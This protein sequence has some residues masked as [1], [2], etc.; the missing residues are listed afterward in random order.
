M[1]QGRDHARRACRVG[2]AGWPRHLFDMV[3]FA[4]CE[5]EDLG[6]Y[7]GEERKRLGEPSW[8]PLD[9]GSVEALVGEPLDQ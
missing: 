4:S 9:R 7:R 5:V 6:R 1:G 2:E 3:T 8:K